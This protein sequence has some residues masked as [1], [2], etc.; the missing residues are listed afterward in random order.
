MDTLRNY[1][2]LP[3]TRRGLSADIEAPDDLGAGTATAQRA[4]VSI[5]FTINSEPVGKDVE[6]LGSGD[7]IGISPRAVVKTEPRNWVTDFEANYLPYIEFY[8]EDFAWRFTPA[9]AANALEQSRLR[10]WIF[11]VVL[12]ESEFTEP[13]RP[14]PL[15]AFELAEGLDPVLLFGRTEQTWAW[16]HVHVSENIIGASLQTQTP[17]DVAAV[18]QNLEQTLAVN[19]DVASSRL[20]CARKLKKSTAYHAFVIPAFEVGRL[21]GLGLDVPPALS[22]Q[23]SAWA[24]GQRL[25]PIYY[26]WFFRTGEQG[27]FE[28]LADLLDPRPADERVGVR[29]MDMQSPGYEV[30][31]MSGA[32]RVMGLEGA[33]KATNMKPS[34]AQWPPAGTVFENPPAGSAGRFLNQLEQKVN[35]QF[36]LQQPADDPHPDP[37]VSPP[38]YGRWYAMAQRLDVQHGVGW[39]D[40]LNRD[41]RLRTPAG[42]GTQVIQ[43]EQEKFMQKA[44]AQLGE[45][46]QTNQKIR[47]LQLAWMSSFTGF[48]KHVLPQPT[49]Q[50]LA[51]TQAVQGRVLGSPTTIAKQ[52]AGS[53]LP[54]AAVDPGFRKIAR[55]RGATMRKVVPAG[56]TR[57]TDIL[58]KLNE[59]KLT[60][61]PTPPE[62]TGQMSLDGAAS[63]IEPPALPAW[64]ARLL[65]SGT[66]TLI[67]LLVLLAIAILLALPTIG[68]VALAIAL[69]GVWEAIRR[70]RQRV[71]QAE[72]LRESFQ[73][74][75]FTPAAVEQIAARPNFALAEFGSD[76]PAVPAGSAADSVEAANFRIALK[77]AFNV[78][79]SP[80]PPRPVPQPL[81]MANAITKLKQAIN[82]AV[83][84]TRRAQFVLKIPASI[85]DGYLRPQPT[86]VT[87]MSHPVF[88]EPMYGPLRDLSAEF[89]A[90]N[91]SLIP[92][93]TVSLLETNQRFIE[94]YMVGLNDEMGRE[95]LWRQFPTDQ[96]GS[97]FRQF[98]D[99]GDAVER[100]A[101]KAPATVEEELLDISK[102]HTWAKET[103][104]GDPTHANR[105]LPSGAEP[106]EAR[107]VLVVRGDLLKKYPT[108]VVYA[109]QAKWVRDEQG[110]MVRVLDESDPAN[111]IQ[112]PKFKAEI[113]P[114][115]RFLGFDLT[116]SKV[117]GDPDPAADNPGWFFVIQERP[118]EPRF[119]LDDLNEESP[120]TPG[121]WN[122]LAWEHLADAQT[123]GC[124][125]FDR[126][127][128]NDSAI[129]AQ[130]DS[131]FKWGRNGADMA[132]ILY[133][134]PV[135]VAFHAADMLP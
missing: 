55:P 36:D 107:L 43:K 42:A 25:H 97:Y 74:K 49:D 10:P 75:S 95:L 40:E 81:Q 21:A 47:Q 13:K 133:Q 123:L 130:P 84:V 69:A 1:T 71:E 33:L 44:W 77:D 83:S 6:V 20:L 15:P 48:R 16:A 103:P 76:M 121:N 99:V 17:Q 72:S 35:L 80:P 31:G 110:N 70:L 126:N 4:A 66:L 111:L 90:P 115:V 2:F 8:E 93:N 116:S 9:S 11:L 132:Y 18:E 91:L 92:N 87:V 58:A 73:E 108:A 82:P 41:P 120:A 119:G 78:Y 62:P 131:Q 24:D 67:F 124:V 26:R 7:V 117:K 22:G 122:E 85:K 135:M 59:G 3:W 23:R 29:S 112:S 109:Q 53:R 127:V 86:L 30:D 32:L 27:D 113:D 65:R 106:G 134:V 54:R 60:A 61:A 51:F 45:L 96:R 88:A 128:P 98:W 46:T 64:L 34:P 101:S 28:F 105:P 125:D 5:A 56:A 38:L 102:L 12:E 104:L 52:L 114:D 89:L 19:A 37:I 94:A 129:T 57:P 63:S 14:G 50:F 118:G 68:I 39:V 79:Q 100:D